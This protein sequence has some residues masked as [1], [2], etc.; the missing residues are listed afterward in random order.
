MIYLRFVV[1]AVQFSKFK[2]MSV[3]LAVAFGDRL[4]AYSLNS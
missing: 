3:N 4:Y 2:E 1:V